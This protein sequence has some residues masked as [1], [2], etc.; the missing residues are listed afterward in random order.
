MFCPYCGQQNPDEAKF[1]GACGKQMELAPSQAVHQPAPPVA[2]APPPPPVVTTPPVVPQPPQP[3]ALSASEPA[4]LQ[5]HVPTHLVLAI[6][7]TLCCGCP[8]VGIISLIFALQVS[9]KL[10]SGDIAGAQRAS[11]RAKLWGIVGIILGLI[12][13]GIALVVYIAQQNNW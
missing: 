10:K 4:A 6:I 13:N 3:A 8:P 9:G 5:F 7:A 1:C 2:A 11:S 12:A